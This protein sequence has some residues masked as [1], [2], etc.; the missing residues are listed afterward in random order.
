[1][2]HFVSIRLWEEVF[3]SGKPMRFTLFEVFSRWGI[4][5]WWPTYKVVVCSRYSKRVFKLRSPR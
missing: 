1:M 4:A 2:R 3:I 5:F